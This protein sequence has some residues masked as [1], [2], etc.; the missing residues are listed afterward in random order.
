VENS[1]VKF[2]DL[3]QRGNIKITKKNNFIILSNKFYKKDIINIEKKWYFDTQKKVMYLH[4][5]IKTSAEIFLTIRCNYFN[6]NHKIF[7]FNKLK[8]STKNGGH[9]KKLFNLKGNESFYHDE[10]LS[11]KFTSQNCFGNTDGNIN[12]SDDKNQI[13]FQI[14]N[15]VGISAPMLN[16]Q[17][18]SNNAYFLRLLMSFKENNDVKSNHDRKVFENLISKKII[19]ISLMRIYSKYIWVINTIKNI[20]YFFISFFINIIASR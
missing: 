1:N 13:N 14:F 10:A 3:D 15:E 11:S 5:K 20:K 7:D 9:I 12:F 8:I 16:F 18:D 19:L 2:S 17:K 4:N 6:L